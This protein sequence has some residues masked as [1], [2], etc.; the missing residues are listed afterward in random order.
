MPV[1]RFGETVGS[2]GGNG[3]SFRRATGIAVAVVAVAIIGIMLSLLSSIVENVNA[4]TIMVVQA[5]TSGKLTWYATTWGLEWQGLGTVT[6]YPKR[7]TLPVKLEVRFNDGGHGTIIG[8]VQ[9]DMPLDTKNL[10]NI[11]TKFGSADAVRDQLVATVVNKAVYMTGPLMSS[12]ESYAE[13]RNDLISDIEDQIQNGV[14]RTRQKEVKVLDPI[15]NQEKAVMAVEIVQM[16]GVAARQEASVLTEF[17]MR[18]YNFSISKLDYDPLVEK[19]IQ[20]QQQI[21]MGVQKAVA[22]A[23]A[24]E[25]RTL[26]ITQ[27][28]LADVAKAKYEQEV[29]KQ[30]AVTEA[31]MARDVAAL[32][33]KEMDQYR[34]SEFKR[35]EADATYRTKMMNADGGLPLKLDTY[36][37]YAQVWANAFQHFNGQLVPNVVMGGGSSAAGGNAIMNMMDILGAKAAS[38]LAVSFRPA[39]SHEQAQK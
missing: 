7:G 18:A 27:T 38:D 2:G 35:A 28:G 34:E 15:T 19:Q 37:K 21:A 24:A 33:N 10:T 8:S 22:E 20:E 5:P 3:L 36:I 11:H 1:T 25:Q 32:R 31:E 39:A 6:K 30:K 23:R 14:Y 17:G 9:Y 26:T 16:N 29:I 4:D 13:K 12:K